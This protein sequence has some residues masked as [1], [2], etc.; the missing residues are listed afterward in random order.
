MKKPPLH[1]HKAA[2]LID[3]HSLDQKRIKI[4][5]ILDDAEKELV[6]LG[7]PY[8]LAALDRD[9]RD[10][11]GGKVFVNSELKGPDMSVIMQHA[12]PSNKDLIFLGLHV[13][14]EI[15]RRNKDAS[16]SFREKKRKGKKAAA[17]PENYTTLPECK[18]C[19]AVNCNCAEN[20]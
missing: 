4:N 3:E 8:F 16:I 2:A 1:P 10:A 9:P 6:A 11:D 17:P 15:M 14:N 5:K 20:N 19:H 18:K 7:C 13:G 12:F